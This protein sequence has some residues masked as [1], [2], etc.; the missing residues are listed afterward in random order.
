MATR[1]FSSVVVLITLHYQTNIKCDVSSRL[2]LI[3]NTP[4]TGYPQMKTK[5]ATHIEKDTNKSLE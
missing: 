4:E 3:P 5:P 1:L 2:H